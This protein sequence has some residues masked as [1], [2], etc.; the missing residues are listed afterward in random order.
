MSARSFFVPVA[1]LALS[2][3]VTAGCS[4]GGLMGEWLLTGMEIDGEDY[5]AYLAGQSYTYD[6]CTYTYTYRMSLEFDDRKGATYT[7]QF[8]QAYSYSYSGT[9]GS[10][11]YSESY[12]YNAEAEKQSK[13][14]YKIGIDDE[15]LNLDCTL[16]EDELACEDDGDE[17]TFERN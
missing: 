13:G 9:C 4:S 11:S 17:L 3:T 6:G 14:E 1:T 5:S 10:E 15:D 8:T 7:G 2:T 16:E 12:S